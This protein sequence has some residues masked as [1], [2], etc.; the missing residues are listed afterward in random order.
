[1]RVEELQQGV[2]RARGARRASTSTVRRGEKIGIIGVNGA[3]KT[4]LLRMIAGELEPT[5][6][7]ITLGY[8]VKVGYYAQH[9]ADTLASRPTR[10]YE[11]SRAPSPTPPPTRVRSMLGAFLFCGDDVDKK[12]GVLSGGERARVAL[13]RLLIKPG[14][15]L[16]MDEP[17][18]HLDLDSSESARRVARAATTARWCSSATT[19]A[20]CAG[21]RRGSGTSRTARSR[22][23]RA[24]STSTWT[25][26]AG[27]RPRTRGDGKPAAS[28]RGSK[29]ARSRGAPQQPQ[30]PQPQHEPSAQ[31]RS[32]TPAR[33]SKRREHEPRQQRAQEKKLAPQVERLEQDIAKL[34]AAQAER[35]AQL[36]DPEVYADKAR[37]QKLI[38]EF[39]AAQ[40]ELEQLQARWE[41]RAD[42]ARS[43]KGRGRQSG[44]AGRAPRG[45]R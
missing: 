26:A 41:T 9:H 42:R 3:G 23:T 24:R 33:A 36:A 30:Q 6:G 15:L 7:T 14:N 32:A 18:N 17:T 45:A 38:E 27:A 44:L 31:P 37:S 43:G 4:T 39:R 13:A 29:P 19:A 40:R 21:W 12:V 22:P 10:V 5:R 1:M 28:R 11:T 35:S 20:S 8:G 25:A 16:L 34:E 2:R